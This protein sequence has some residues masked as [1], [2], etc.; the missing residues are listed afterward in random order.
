MGG[1]WRIEEEEEERRG[2]E[3][4]RRRSRRSAE[5]EVGRGGGGRRRMAGRQASVCSE[6]DEN[7]R[8]GA[9]SLSRTRVRMRA[10]AAFVGSR[11]GCNCAHAQ[12]GRAAW[13]GT[14]VLSVMLDGGAFTQRSFTY[15]FASSNALGARAGAMHGANKRAHGRG[16]PAVAGC[17]IYDFKIFFSNKG[18]ERVHEVCNDIENRSRT[19]EG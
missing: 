5:E 18:Q 13:A 1:T 11:R 7:F 4:R 15:V 2:E 6:M 17:S 14:G 10:V 16:G 3:R 19:M 8:E 9:F 12:A